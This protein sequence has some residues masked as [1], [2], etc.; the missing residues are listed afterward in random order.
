MAD[1][2][3][4]A[5]I[6]VADA[7][8]FSAAFRNVHF[9]VWMTPGSAEQ[10]RARYVV[11]HA[12]FKER[13]EGKSVTISV[14]HPAAVKPVEGELRKVINESTLANMK[15]IKAGAIVILATGF[16][17]AVIR[18]VIAALTLLTGARY[19][20]K[21]CDAV[22]DGLKFA[23]EQCTDGTTIE[24]LRAAWAQ[25]SSSQPQPSTSSSSSSAKPA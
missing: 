12:W 9:D 25:L 7:G 6:L 3:D 20:T 21:T 1:R 15:F 14:I 19:P 10:F 5:R 4:E 23:C 11:Q 16:R 22:D 24:Q 13:G 18:G 17:A 2:E 8:G